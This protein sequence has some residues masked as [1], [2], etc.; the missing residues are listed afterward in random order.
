MAREVQTLRLHSLSDSHLVTKSIPAVAPVPVEEPPP[1][2]RR[3]VLWTVLTVVLAFVVTLGVASLAMYVLHRQPASTSAEPTAASDVKVVGCQRVRE[4]HSGAVTVAVTNHTDA[5]ASYVI[6]VAFENASGRIRYDLV[7]L[8][9]PYLGA[10]QTTTVK[11]RDLVQLP[12]GFICKTVAITRQK[13]EP[14]TSA[15]G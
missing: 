8:T 5:T 10:G 14:W 3:W 4:Y 12:D 15:T 7:T 6:A 11:N 2:R 1:P 13:V 9:V